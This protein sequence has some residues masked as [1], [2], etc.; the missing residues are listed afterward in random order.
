ML[1]VYLHNTNQRLEWFYWVTLCLCPLYCSCLFTR[2]DTVPI[3]CTGMSTQSKILDEHLNVCITLHSNK[4]AP[5]TMCLLFVLF[6]VGCSEAVKR[7]SLCKLESGVLDCSGL[8]LSRLPR[9][10]IACKLGTQVLNINF[11]KFVSVP[12]LTGYGWKHLRTVSLLENPVTCPPFCTHAK[13]TRRNIIAQCEC[14]E[15]Y[16]VDLYIIVK[17]LL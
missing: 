12:H 15:H 2:C 4:M 10:P 6:F 8:G 13:D 11:N 3:P 17:G 1:S 14:G 5:T 7:C 16:C 9:I